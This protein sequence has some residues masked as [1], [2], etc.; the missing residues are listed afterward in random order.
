MLSLSSY[1]GSLVHKAMGVPPSELHAKYAPEALDMVL[2]LGGYYIKISQTLVGAHILPKEYDDVFEKLLDDVPPK[3]YS[4]IKEIVEEQL[5]APLE[6][7]FSSFNE[8]PIG[9]AS[10][11]QVHKAT[12]NN[13]KEVVV[14][15][16]YPSVEKFFSIDIETMKVLCLAFGLDPKITDNIVK[17]LADSFKSEFNYQKEADFMAKVRSNV[18]PK[19]GNSVYIPSSFPNLCTPK[20]LTMEKIEGIPIKKKLNALMEHMAKEKGLTL[21][22]YMV[23]QKKRY[24]DPAKLEEMMKLRS[25]EKSVGFANLE[26]LVVKALDYVQNAGRLVLRRPLI[27]TPEILNGPQIIKVLADV[28]GHQV[29]VDGVYNSDPHAGNVIVMPDG[30][31]GL[32][33]YGATAEMDKKNREAL[34]KIIVAVK[35]SDEK[36]IITSMKDFGISSKKMN[37]IFMLGYANIC[38]N[39]GYNMADMYAIGVPRDVGVA[40]LEMYLNKLDELEECSK[41]VFQIQRCI[42]VLLGTQ[43]MIG[44]GGVSIAERW[45][46]Q[47]RDFLKKK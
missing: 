7:N 17:G 35:D 28:H 21:Q 44:A 34:A 47:A 37:R 27:W 40:D 11:G 25:K 8:K 3:P 24:E 30:R 16:Q 2:S 1:I 22:E 46:Q 38:F 31:L 9:A 45:N 26:I 33:D 10:I 5:Q 15:V 18:L 36:S 32:I 19:F 43:S 29:F 12:L 41:E 14:K 42:M 23:E 4:D 13:G 6:T 20:V 39:R